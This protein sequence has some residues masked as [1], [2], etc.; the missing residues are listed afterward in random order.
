M[1][2]TVVGGEPGSQVE[3]LLVG[4]GGAGRNI[5]AVSHWAKSLTVDS[6]ADADLLVDRELLTLRKMSPSSTIDSSSPLL[7]RLRRETEGTDMLLLTGALGGAA[8]SLSIAA[9]SNAGRLLGT[10]VIVSAAMPFDV[11]GQMR[12]SAAKRALSHIEETANVTIVFENSIINQTMPNVR[13]TRAL[14]IMNRIILSPLQE[15]VRCTDVAFIRRIGRERCRGVYTVCHSS[16]ID[17][18]RKGGYAIAAELGEQAG[19]L[20]ELHLFLTM[21]AA[22]PDSPELLGEEAARRTGDCSTTVWV[23]GRGKV[24]ENRIGVLGLI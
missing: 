9:L 16:G 3:S 24:G 12:R 5:V 17:W 10:T 18:E 1:S 4:C 14:D 19:R 20:R 23:K 11:E 8:G 7:G 2:V 13:V 6:G 15:I 21:G 22:A